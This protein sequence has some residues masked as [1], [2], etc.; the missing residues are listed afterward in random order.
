MIREFF[1]AIDAN[2]HMVGCGALRILGD[3]LAEVRS[4]AVSDEVQGQGVGRRLVQALTQ[5]AKELE[6]SKVFALTLQVD[7]FARLGF[8][9]VDKA[10]FPQK[11][12][13]DCAGCPKQAHCD[14]T[15]MELSW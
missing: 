7:F 3:D 10:T 11:V 14:E 2:G 9:I 5:E 4:L 1:V 8:K 15:A 12:W 6:L 13:L